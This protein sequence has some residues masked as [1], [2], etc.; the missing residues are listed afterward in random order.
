[1]PAVRGVSFEVRQGEIV[2]VAGVSGN[3]QRELA[4]A[5]AGLTPMTEGTIMLSGQQISGLSS[6]AINQRPFAHVPRIAP[7]T[8]S[9]CS[10]R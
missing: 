4:M 1:L 3:G 7:L 10:C 5:L 9:C 2:G 8:A 6:R